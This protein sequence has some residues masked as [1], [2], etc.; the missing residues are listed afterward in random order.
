MQNHL[1]LF[2]RGMK[3]EIY[4]S[5]WSK[6]GQLGLSFYKLF[7]SKYEIFCSGKIYFLKVEYKRY[8]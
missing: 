6:N 3:Y 8:Y 7:H 4:S 2:H 1:N 5:N